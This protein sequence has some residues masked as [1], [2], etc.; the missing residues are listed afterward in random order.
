MSVFIQ[1]DK[2]KSSMYYINIHEPQVN[3]QFICPFQTQNILLYVTAIIVETSCTNILQ[4]TYIVLSAIEYIATIWSTVS[5]R[6]TDRSHTNLYI[7]LQVP[8]NRSRSAVC[9]NPRVKSVHQ[10]L[11]GQINW[12]QSICCGASDQE[13]GL[14]QKQ[15][16]PQFSV[17]FCLCFPFRR[18]IK[19]LLY[20]NQTVEEPCDNN[21][22]GRKQTSIYTG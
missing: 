21:N 14:P 16:G 1:F 7:L 13:G 5:L 2:F 19:S 22:N 8:K 6:Q 18:V 12:T 4:Q 9:L 20:D 17:L 11:N 3:I 10:G 15:L